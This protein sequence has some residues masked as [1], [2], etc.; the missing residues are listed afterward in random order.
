MVAG[1][2]Y[3]VDSAPI[4]ANASVQSLT[5]KEI[6]ADGDDYTDQLNADDTLPVN[7]MSAAQKK[8]NR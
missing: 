6:L 5:E 8:S 3:A 4:K 7:T 1:K 2:R